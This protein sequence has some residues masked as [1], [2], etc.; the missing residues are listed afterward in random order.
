MQDFFRIRYRQC[1][2]APQD[3]NGHSHNSCYELIQPLTDGGSIL[4]R[5][6]IYPMSQGSL[7]LINGMTVMQYMKEQRLSLAKKNLLETKSPIVD[8]A[9]SCGFVNSSRFS[10][11]FRQNTGMS[12]REYRK[13][14]TRRQPR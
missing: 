11:A 2:A 14:Y 8:A 7:Y 3:R 6:R 10:K 5:D 13:K 1:G 9:L 4:I 12:P